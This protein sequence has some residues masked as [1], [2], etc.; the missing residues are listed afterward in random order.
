MSSPR[1]L[2]ARDLIGTRVKEI[3]TRRGLTAA[4][5]AKRCNDIGAK[6]ITRDFVTNLETKR[7]GLSVDDVFVL[8]FALDVAPLALL[9]LDATKDEVI[10]VAESVAVVDPEE[11]RN[12]LVGDAALEGTDAKLY[13][14]AALETMEA[15]GG[16]A[17]SAYVRSLVAE[18][19]R[20]LLSVYNKQAMDLLERTQRQALALLDDVTEEVSSGAPA[21]QI[22]QRLAGIRANIV[23][24][25]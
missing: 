3:R 12:W 6:H 24:S 19:Q 13:Y 25:T 4:A 7:R 2:S 8:A 5:L 11:W 18:R 21:A 17:M 20:E 15:P 23:S 14:G 9:A 22:L 1:Q 10:A 16:Q